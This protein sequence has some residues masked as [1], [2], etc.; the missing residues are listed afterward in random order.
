M[1]SNRNAVLDRIKHLE[2]ALAKGRAYLKSGEHAQ[3]HGFRALFHN[4][5]KEG[6]PL[7]PHPEWVKNFFLPSRE[8]ALR[9]AEKALERFNS[10]RV[11]K[12]R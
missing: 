6:E 9:R 12:D 1:N 10:H 3:W 5:Q 11:G 7:P 2:D 8:R 4:K